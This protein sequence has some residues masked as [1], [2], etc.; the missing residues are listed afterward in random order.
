VVLSA[1]DTYRAGSIQQ[2]QKHADNLN[3]KLIAQNYGSDPASV[4]ID[5]IDHA[6]SN[7]KDIVIIDTAGR[8]QNNVNL[9]RELEKIIRLT[10]PHLKLFIGDALAGNDVIQ[11]ADKFNAEIDLDGIIM[12]KLDSDIKGGAVISIANVIKK[13]ILFLGVGQS[14]DD[15][16]EFEPNKIMEQVLGR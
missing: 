11:Q 7:N 10:E 8:M 3:T 16:I 14:Y 1:S 6:E 13:P 4:A 12:T 9:V 15:L 2:I 5:A